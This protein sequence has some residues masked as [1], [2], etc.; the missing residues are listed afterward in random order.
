MRGRLVLLSVVLVLSSS[1]SSLAYGATPD[2]NNETPEISN[3]SPK[4]NAIPNPWIE[5][6]LFD[7]SENGQKNIRVTAI[8]SSLG[9]LDSWQRQMGAIDRQAPAGPGESLSHNEI[10]S[11]G[12]EHRTFWVL[13]LIHI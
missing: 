6:S 12:T 2:D 8:T 1:L 4:V 3:N 10:T 9:H 5:Q 13:S 11:S 7:R